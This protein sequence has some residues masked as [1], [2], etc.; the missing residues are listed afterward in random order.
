[1]ERLALACGGEQVNA[2]DELRKDQLGYAGVV[3]EQARRKAYCRFPCTLEYSR[4]LSSTGKART[5]DNAWA[6]G[7][8]V[9]GGLPPSA[10]ER[11]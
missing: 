8:A 5:Q 4:V 9:R 3:Y 6:N 1:M 10:A 11:R 2:V 7:Q